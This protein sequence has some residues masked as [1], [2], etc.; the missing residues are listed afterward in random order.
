MGKIFVRERRQNGPG[1][2]KP[3]FAIVAVLGTD[4]RVFTRHIRKAEL[5]KLA[6]MTGAEIVYLPRGEN[7][8]EDEEVVQRGHRRGGG[9]Q[10]GG[11]R[12]VD[13]E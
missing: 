8:R 9:R 5:E 13:Q 7:A 6:E 11:A 3:R 1:S 10:H 2:G 4:L 12:M